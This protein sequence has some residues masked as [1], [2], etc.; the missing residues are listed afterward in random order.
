MELLP[1]TFKHKDSLG[2]LLDVH[3]P[4]PQLEISYNVLANF[5]QLNKEGVLFVERT[6]PFFPQR[7]FPMFPALHAH[8]F[9]GTLVTTSLKTTDQAIK[10]PNLSK[11]LYLITQPEW[12]VQNF[13]NSLEIMTNSRIKLVT[14]QPQIKTLIET[15]FKVKCN[16]LDIKDFMSHEQI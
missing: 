11:I 1:Q 15:K 10:M 4:S 9:T 5:N 6:Y 16:L 8:S 3:Q 13:E 14:L 7:N 12:V 2:F